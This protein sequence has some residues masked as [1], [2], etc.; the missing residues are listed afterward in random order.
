MKK[1]F[2]LITLLF[3]FSAAWA[4][5]VQ[6]ECLTPVNGHTASL[7]FKVKVLKS[8]KFQS[9]T[10][11]EKNEIID[12]QIK[13]IV[14]AKAL[15]RSSYIVVKPVSKEKKLSDGETQVTPIKDVYLEGKTTSIKVLSKNDIK[16]NIEENW[17]DDLKKAGIGASK[18]AINSVVPGAT[19]IYQA[20]K[21]LINPNEGESRLKSAGQ[22]VVDNTALKHL[23]KGHDIN[24]KSGDKLFIKFYHSDVPKW[25]FIKRNS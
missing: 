18:M 24:I 6:M 8:V 13:E 4:K 12:L 7:D 15:G 21:G 20:S 23:K 11:F 25:R 22:N 16:N 10:T 17:Q 2:I 19:T 14:P 5:E 1:I 3:I 9:G